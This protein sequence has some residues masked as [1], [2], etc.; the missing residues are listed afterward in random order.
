MRR[1]SCFFCKDK[2]R[3]VDYKDVNQLRRYN[4]GRGK[5]RAAALMTGACRRPQAGSSP[6]GESSG[7]GR[8]DAALPLRC[9]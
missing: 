6:A 4:L 9:R 7:P 8:L 2:V 1:K 5:I 3:E